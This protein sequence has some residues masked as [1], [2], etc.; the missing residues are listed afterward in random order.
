MT[1]KE[2]LK[3]SSEDIE[4]LKDVLTKY[5]NHEK[6]EKWWKNKPYFK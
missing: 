5:F 3:L 2:A 6:R 1:L 4:K